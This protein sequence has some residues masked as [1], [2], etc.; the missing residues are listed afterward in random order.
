MGQKCCHP[1]K[2]F[3]DLRDGN[4]AKKGGDSNYKRGDKKAATNTF[5]QQPEGKYLLYLTLDQIFAILG[6]EFIVTRRDSL[7]MAS[8]EYTEKIVQ[9]SKE[10]LPLAEMNPSGRNS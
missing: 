1:S 5:K 2:D 3:G 10:G 4:T 6:P 9:R 7:G 8:K